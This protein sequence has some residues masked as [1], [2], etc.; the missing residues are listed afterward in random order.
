MKKLLPP[1]LFILSIVVMGLVCWATGSEHYI[2]YPYNLIGMVWLAVGLGMAFWGSRLFKK[3]GTNIMTF[4]EP[5]VMVTGGL[6]KFSRN[7]MYLG[8]VIAL[9]GVAILFQG[10]IISFAVVLVFFVVSDRWYIRYEEAE[11]LKKFG[12]Q[13]EEY[14]AHTR[15][16]F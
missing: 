13:Y 5:G 16:W 14:C 15:R 9:L 3:L 12:Q 1:V 6:Y 8:F 7:P 11:M 4:A 2:P 10:S